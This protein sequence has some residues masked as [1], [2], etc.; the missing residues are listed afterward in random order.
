VTSSFT[1]WNNYTMDFGKMLK[2]P[3]AMKHFGNTVVTWDLHTKQPKKV[4]DVPGAPLG[5][6]LRLGREPQL[7]LSPPPR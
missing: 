1:G 3:E 4:F 2:D 5:N 6:P 7:L